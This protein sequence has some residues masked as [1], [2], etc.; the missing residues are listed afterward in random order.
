MQPSQPVRRNDSR[1]IHTRG[2]DL[3]KAQHPEIRRLKRQSEPSI[4][5][6]KVWNSSF[7]IMDHLQREGFPQG[8]H[9]MDLGCGWGPLAIYAARRFDARVT[10]VDADPEVFP[11]LHLHAG[12]NGVDVHTRQRRFERLT[13][14]DMSGV[15]TLAGADICFWTELTD[16]QFKLIRRA[17]QAGVQRIII[18]DPGRDPFYQ[19]VERCNEYFDT[20]LLD[21]RTSTPRPA[22]ADLLVIERD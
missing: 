21:R 1:V 4:H 15:H 7:V 5:G 10:A 11:Y 13:K 20:R 9:L 12:I 6:N 2:I 16:V 8:E 14:K 17:W 3:L 19:L 22:S 18:A